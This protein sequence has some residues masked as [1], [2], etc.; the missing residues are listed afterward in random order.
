LEKLEETLGYSQ[1]D[2]EYL[3]HFNPN[4]VV[5][6]EYPDGGVLADTTEFLKSTF[7]LTLEETKEI[8]LRYPRFLNTRQEVIEER[9]QFYKDLGLCGE[10]M[11]QEEINDIFK[12]NPFYILCPQLHF[13]RIMSEFKKYKFTKEEAIFMI[14]KAPGILSFSGG[15]MKN[16][17]DL[18][19]HL[20]KVKASDFKEIILRYPEIIYQANRNHM[21]Q[22]LF[23]I[24]KNTNNSQIYLRDMFLRHPTLFMKSMASFIAK[25]RFLVIHMGKNLKSERCFP[26]LLKLNLNG[27]IKPR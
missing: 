17:F 19:K 26:L 14:K 4:T 18:L 9:L 7:N 15:S 13:P 20:L 22:K 25:E 21:H 5:P 24:R 12:E 3:F 23:I 2:I 27:F 1:D 10:A 16:L 11:S 8:L 6:P